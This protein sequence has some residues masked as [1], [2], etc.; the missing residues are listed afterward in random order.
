MGM[1]GAGDGVGSR[2][3]EL[4]GAHGHGVLSAGWLIG[5]HRSQSQKQ[6]EMAVI[7]DFVNRHTYT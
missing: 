2:R 6:Q 4:M 5:N 7:D 1:S 3:W